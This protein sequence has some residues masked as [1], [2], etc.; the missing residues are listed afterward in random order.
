MESNSKDEPRKP[1]VETDPRFP[2][3]PWVGFWIQGGLGKQKMRLILSF[4]EGRINGGGTDIVGRFAFDGTYD[5]K[6]GRCLMTKQYEGAH[7]VGY[8]GVNQGDGLWIWG[9]WHQRYT[10]GGFH[11]WPEGEEDPTERRTG[12]EAKLPTGRQLKRG[13]LLEV[14]DSGG[15]KSWSEN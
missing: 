6:T 15:G 14:V 3:G 5:L 12:A 4:A 9:L 11:L 13:E 1:T 2:S 8:D 10:R 7:R